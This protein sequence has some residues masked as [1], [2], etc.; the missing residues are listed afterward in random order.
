MN[1]S[2]F[3]EDEEEE[4]NYRKCF[5]I[6]SPSMYFAYM[7]MAS[8]NNEENDD[9]N[10]GNDNENN[11]CQPFRNIEQTL[12][13]VAN[14]ERL[15]ILFKLKEDNNSNK[16][17]KNNLSN[18]SKDL[19][20]IVQEVHR[21]TNRLLKAGLVQKD[22][23]TGYFSLTTFGNIVVMQ[24]SALDF[25]S[26]N[27]NYFSDHTLG[28]LPLKFIQR[29]GSLVNSQL[30]TN[31]VAVF[32]Y[33]K[34]LFST[35]RSYVYTILPEVPQYLIDSV[36]PMIEK[37]VRLRYILSY[38]A[39]LPKKRHNISKHEKF[40]TLINKEIV[41]RRMIDSAQIGLIINE[42]QSMVSFCTVKD[43]IDMNSAFCSSDS[44]FHD[45]CLDYFNYKWENSKSYNPE[46]I[47]E[48]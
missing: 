33:Q 28:D 3:P 21:H 39:V 23:S 1:F 11:S 41:Q 15:S 29:V 37:G 16:N 10:D 42:N 19:N 43:K 13:E 32:E 20:I 2:P 25:I 6:F 46:K 26:N 38:N 17:N 7:Y 47:T 35:S 14:A 12:F 22:S 34:E 36:M 30:L 9:D 44:T 5:S 27:R 24:L 40:H 31:S 48:A 45:W 4:D 18:L 8:G